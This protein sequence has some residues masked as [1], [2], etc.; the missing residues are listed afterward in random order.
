MNSRKSQIQTQIFV[1]VIA[2]VVF[3]F[4]IIYGYNAVRGFKERSDQIAYIKFKT[5]LLSTVKRISPDYGT[6]KREEFFIGGEYSKV[7][8]VQNYKPNKAQI[9][10]SIDDV[11]GDLIVKNSV[12]SDVNKNV[13]LFTTTLQESFDVGAINVSGDG[14]TCVDIKNGKAKIQFKGEGD[15]TYISNWG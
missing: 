9:L 7:C 14:Y 1:Y 11:S 8:F 6:V 13:F 5:D 12:E 4:I 10:N 15:H 3:S 2:V